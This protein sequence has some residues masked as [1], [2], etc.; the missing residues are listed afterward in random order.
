MGGNRLSGLGVGRLCGDPEVASEEVRRLDYV[1][2][3]RVLPFERGRRVGL[4]LTCEQALGP[5]V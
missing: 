5:G 4:V 1:S 3:Q 2:G